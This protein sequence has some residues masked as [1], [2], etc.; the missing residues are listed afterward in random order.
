MDGC[1]KVNTKKRRKNRNENIFLIM[2]L[3]K[4]I[5]NLKRTIYMY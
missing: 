4:I 3:D 2:R 1:I 5:M